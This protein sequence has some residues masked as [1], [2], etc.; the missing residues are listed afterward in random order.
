[1]IQLRAA[2][3]RYP[4]GSRVGPVDLEVRAGELVV[5]T[6]PTGCG[7]STLLRLAAGLLQRHGAGVAE[8]EVRVGG[9]DPAGLVAAERVRA[10]GFV[11]QDP[12]DQLVGTG[13]TA[14]VAFA[15][16]AA[17]TPTEEVGPRVEAALAR[18]GLAG[19]GGGDPAQFSGGMRQR[20]VI[21]AALAAGARALL[22]DEPLAQLDPQGA[23]EVVRVVRG[24][25]AEGVAVLMVEHRLEHVWD[26]AHRL[27]LMDEGRVVAD[28]LLD[29]A[30]LRPLRLR[31]PARVDLDARLG[32]GP[33]RRRPEAPRP[34]PPVAA[35]AAVLDLAEVDLVRRDD[36]RLRVAAFRVGRGERVA[37]VGANGSGKSTLLQVAAGQ[38]P[39]GRRRAGRVV[40]VP[41]DPDLAL[42]C[43]TVRE[44]LAYGPRE[45]GQDPDPM[46][47]RWARAL[48]VDELL[49]RPPQAL[50]RGQRLR[51]AVAAAGA[52]GP[53]LLVL[54][55]PTSGQDLGQVDRM[56]AGLEAELGD[57]ALLYAC[58]DLDVVLRHATRVV[59]LADGRIVADGPPRDVLPRAGLPLP[60]LARLCL[61]LDLPHAPTEAVA[62]WLE[63][64]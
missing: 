44:E 59:A 45:A 28:P 40:D 3:W 31:P 18:V 49:D 54:D 56:F 61:E 16:H 19:H 9:R 41:Q 64:R 42:F 36:W 55:E 57:A 6:G 53:H 20:L 2:G 32:G 27:V 23:A 50:S 10:L 38:L 1:M 39:A 12:E 4:G 24:L 33:W 5:L 48:A 7:K 11:A 21:A 52:C 58:H 51:V 60:D 13:V 63:R 26:H 30:A 25:A 34:V 22:L 8:G 29:I 37:L 14:E 43:P 47:R 35:G 62:A 17:G 46:V 15:L